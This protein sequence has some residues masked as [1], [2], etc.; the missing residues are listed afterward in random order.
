MNTNETMKPI[1]KKESIGDE[2]QTPDWLYNA[3][4]SEFHFDIDVACNFKNS[5]A[6]FGLFGTGLIDEWNYDMKTN[7]GAKTVFCNPPYSNITP[8]VRKAVEQLDNGVTSVFLVPSS[9][10]TAWFQFCIYNAREIRFITSDG[11]RSGR[12]H[13]INPNTKKTV[14]GNTSGSCIIVFKPRGFLTP[15]TPKISYVTINDLRS[16]ND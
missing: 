15:N 16:R 2:W 12:V 13:F 5:K 11:K 1:E 10:D 9:T 7:H 3:L 14:T 6:K 4:D 8:W